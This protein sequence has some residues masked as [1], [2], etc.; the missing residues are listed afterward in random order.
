M[1]RRGE[2]ANLRFE[3]ATMPLPTTL[4]LD[5]FRVGDDP[6]PKSDQL[7]RVSEASAVPTYLHWAP[8]R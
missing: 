1:M 4:F 2:A 3:H 5:K 7:E 6:G 8:A